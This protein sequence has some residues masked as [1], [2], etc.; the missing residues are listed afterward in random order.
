MVKRA[1]CALVLAA[2]LSLQAFAFEPRFGGFGNYYLAAWIEEEVE[3]VRGDTSIS[4]EIDELLDL[5]VE[6]S[7]YGLSREQAI[8]AMLRN[9][10][11]NYDAVPHLANSL[12][13][14]FDEFGGYFSPASAEAMFSGAF[15]GYGV[16]LDG[17]YMLDGHLYSVTIRRVFPDSPAEFAGLQA[18]DEFLEINGV[19]VEGMG[20]PAVSNLL[21][22]IEGRADIAVRRGERRVNASMERD[23]VFAASLMFEA[24]GE[25]IA[26]VTVDDFVDLFVAYDFYWALEYLER[27]GYGKLII[28]LR[29]N[30]GGSLY[31]MAT[32]LNMLVVEADVILCSVR[33][34]DGEPE[35]LRSTG[36]GF[37][38]ERIAVLVDRRTESAPEIFAKSLREITGAAVIGGQ[39][40]G[41]GI[42]QHFV[43]LSSGDVAAITAFEVISSEGVSYHGRGVEPDIKVEQ[44]FNSVERGSLEP[45]NF[46]NSAGIKHGADNMAVY[47]LNQRLARIGYIRPCDVTSELTGRTVTAVEVFQKFHG[48]PVGIGRVDFRFIELLNRRASLAPTSYQYGDAVLE[49]A[50]EYI[51]GGYVNQ[52]E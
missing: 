9:F 36:G 34:R 20:L 48:L 15:R 31:I 47:A 18:G 22:S 21:T 2:A 7:L 4:P 42:G 30:G 12:L 29:G 19:N 33:G 46:V 38:F 27:E 40:A 49:R 5:Y 39:T 51:L 37:A 11:L 17:R 14:V 52:E 41:K 26:L 50:I 10:L 35:S 43:E 23:T 45:L 13:T 6:L 1:V 8:L 44:V 3:R 32:M 24:L 25:G 28:D 16:M